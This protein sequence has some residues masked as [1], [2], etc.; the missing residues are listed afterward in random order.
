MTDTQLKCHTR[1]RKKVRHFSVIITQERE[2]VGGGEGQS[3]DRE[4]ERETK[5]DRQTD[6]EY[7]REVK[8]MDWENGYIIIKIAQKIQATKDL[9]VLSVSYA[10]K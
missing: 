5:R 2:R 7:G 6:R 9:S 10:A 4:R 3:T 1:H 8:N